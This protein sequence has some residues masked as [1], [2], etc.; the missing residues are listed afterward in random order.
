[1]SIG[2]SISV[3]MISMNEERAITSVI[4]GIN[5]NVP[6]AEIILVDSSS[7]KTP[8]LASNFSNV[9]VFRQL[10]PMGYGP[11]MT[12]GFRS[13]TREVIVTMDCDNTYPADQ[14]LVMGR[15]VKKDGYDVVDGSRLQARPK[16]MPL[17]NYLANLGFARIASVF[18]MRNLKDLHSGMRAYNRHALLSMGWDTNGRGHALPVELLLKPLRIG[19]KVKIH[20]IGYYQR[21]GESKMNPLPSA[22]WTMVRIFRARFASR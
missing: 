18:F 6:N 9:K 2:S 14:I 16:N 1:M 8:E 11:A 22:Y 7:D 3:V 17:I 10:P 21:I 15:L 12:L 5:S 20:F 19:L 4:N 13:A